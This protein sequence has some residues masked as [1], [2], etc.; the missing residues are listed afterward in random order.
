MKCARPFVLSILFVSLCSGQATP[1]PRVLRNV[2]PAMKRDVALEAAIRHETGDEAFSYSYNLVSL[3]GGAAVDALVYLPG[4]DYCGSGGCTAL[5]FAG[6]SGGYRLIS[7]LTPARVSIFVSSH[8]TNG[9]N[10]LILFVAGG[11]VQPG[12]YW[13]L[14]FDGTRYP[15][16]PSTPPAGPLQHSADAI[17]Y[18]VGA[19]KSKS[20]I[21]V[22]PR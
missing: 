20:G 19:D 10:D 16:N 12:Y 2:V 15:E 3:Q 6:S 1:H 9:W 11:G 4:R 8:R 18:L 21:V 17:A 14:T 22:S 13:V 7:R 5:V